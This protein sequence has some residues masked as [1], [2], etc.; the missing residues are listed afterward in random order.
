MNVTELQVTIGRLHSNGTLRTTRRDANAQ[1]REHGLADGQLPA[2]RAEIARQEAIR[3]QRRRLHGLNTD[4]IGRTTP[5][6]R[7]DWRRASQA[8]LQQR[9]RAERIENALEAERQ[10]LAAAIPALRRR[11]QA[12]L[13]NLGFTLERSAGGS[14]Y[15]IHTDHGV[16][17]RISNHDVPLTDERLAAGFTWAD[18]ATSLNLA[19]AIDDETLY[20]DWQDAVAAELHR[21]AAQWNL[22]LAS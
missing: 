3:E 15:Y 18:A 16:R 17:A 11:A 12:H 6:Q 14:N 10:R 5:Q 1:A 4:M 21:E 13:R 20:A 2:W 19:A 9:E 7:L 22:S 8:R